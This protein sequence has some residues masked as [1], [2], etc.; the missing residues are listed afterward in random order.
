MRVPPNAISVSGMLFGMAAGVAYYH[1]QDVRWAIA[2][3]I[4]MIAWHVMDGADGQL[5]RLTRS[6]SQSGKVLDGIC[7]YVTFIAV[8]VGLA[9]SLARQYGDWIWI[10]V[11]AAG[12]CHAVQAAAYEL[13]RQEYDFWVS[14]R[15]S[16]EFVEPTAVPPDADAS[17]VRRFSDG[18]YRAYVKVQFLAT[19]VTVEFH[20]RLALALELQPER[21]ASLRQRYRE[22]FAPSVR[23]WSVMSSNYRT[24]GIFI[25][26]VSGA[27]QYY[28]WFEA[29]GFNVILELLLN[30][31][32]DLYARF[33][34]G[35][36]SVDDPAVGLPTRPAK[37]IGRE[38]D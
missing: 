8:Y 9:V 20:N 16:A 23:R 11:S 21:A 7:D 32:R 37:E 31:R 29:I 26:A 6:Q 30:E 2:G 35:I 5:A 34:K 10:L 4:L 1:Y 25:C 12:M 19:G 15:K 17:P 24:L 38:N 33:F 3:F 22:G 28:F 27:P 13:Q 36:E 18:L 14:G